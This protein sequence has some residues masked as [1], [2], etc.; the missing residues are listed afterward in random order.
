MKGESSIATTDETPSP[1]PVSMETGNVPASPPPSPMVSEVSATT[2]DTLETIDTTPPSTTPLEYLLMTDV[3]VGRGNYAPV[4]MFQKM[5]PVKVSEIPYDIDGVQVY[6]A[7]T[8]EKAVSSDT[9]DMHYFIM[10]W[11][12]KRNFPGITK[13]GYCHGYPLC[14][15]AKCPFL[16]TSENR[17]PNRIYWKSYRT[18]KNKKVCQIC[19]YY[20]TQE[21]YPARKMAQWNK[22][23]NIATVYH[24]GFHKCTPRADLQRRKD[25]VQNMKKRKAKD[26]E[27]AVSYKEARKKGVDRVAS[28]V[29]KGQI[30]E[31]QEEAG[32]WTDPSLASRVLTTDKQKQDEMEDLAGDDCNSFSA[33]TI[34]K[35]GIGKLD[36]NY[37][38]RLNNGSMNN[39]SDYVFMTSTEMAQLALKMDIDGRN[40]CI[41]G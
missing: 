28:V 6:E 20:A 3:K 27:I 1:Q 16:D 8:T 31:A 39:S 14:P 36:P 13:T 37:I 2:Y 35:R 29:G 21:E 24:L 41:T 38:Y 9:R 18:D 26:S 32:S 15:N 19:D 4:H 34:I 22:E 23:T 5:S 10:R 17:Q 40:Q 11:S 12:G 30:E 33:V 7:S 25:I